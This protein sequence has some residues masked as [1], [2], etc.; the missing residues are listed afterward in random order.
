MWIRNKTHIRHLK[1]DTSD[2]DLNLPRCYTMSNG[3]CL[4]TFRT[5]LLPSSSASLDCITLRMEAL[6]STETSINT[7]H[8][9]WYSKRFQSSTQSLDLTNLNTSWR[10]SQK[11][12][13]DI[14]C[15]NFMCIS[16]HKI[17]QGNSGLLVLLKT[18]A[19]FVMNSVCAWERSSN[20]TIKKLSHNGCHHIYSL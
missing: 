11:N 4:Q 7:G 1:F 19:P 9:G 6:P 8:T 16:V 20:R 5:R 2:K 12:V 13:T 15:T 17:F 3:N 14:C 18:V 10:V